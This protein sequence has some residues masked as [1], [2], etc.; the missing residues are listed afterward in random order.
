MRVSKEIKTLECP[1]WAKTL[2]KVFSQI[3]LHRSTEVAVVVDQG[4]Q[5]VSNLQKNFVLST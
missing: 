2:R 5:T 1:A 3:Q 4:D